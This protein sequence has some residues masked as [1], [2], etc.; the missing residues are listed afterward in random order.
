MLSPGSRGCVC[1]PAR[2]RPACQ[3]D[4]KIVHTNPTPV[5][6]CR[7]PDRRQSSLIT[8]CIPVSACNCSTLAWGNWRWTS[9]CARDSGQRMCSM[10]CRRRGRVRSRW[11]ST[12]WNASRCSPPAGPSNVGGCRGHAPVRSSG[13]EERQWDD[14]DA[15]GPAVGDGSGRDDESI[16]KLL[17]ELRLQPIQ[18]TDVMVADGA[19]ELHLDRDDSTI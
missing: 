18:M 5:Q 12:S 13:T 8:L 2:L 14:G 3:G 1:N 4:E 6:R 15:I 9:S 11:P 17:T 10:R 19:S 7:Y 16:G